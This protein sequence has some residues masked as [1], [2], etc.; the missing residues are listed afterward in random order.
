MSLHLDDSELMVCELLGREVRGEDPMDEDMSNKHTELMRRLL[1]DL[2][3]NELIGL[4]STLGAVVA[5]YSVDDV[6][7]EFSFRDLAQRTGLENMYSEE[8]LRMLEN[9]INNSINE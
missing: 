3:L 6:T 2:S 7:G 1:N 9:D 8:T 4:A 5:C